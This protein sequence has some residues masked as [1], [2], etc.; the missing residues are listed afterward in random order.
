VSWVFGSTRQSLDWIMLAAAIV[1]WLAG[2]VTSTIFRR[3]TP[4][5]LKGRC[6]LG[7]IRS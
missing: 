6:L 5:P 7:E 4:R 2:V 3:R 1:G